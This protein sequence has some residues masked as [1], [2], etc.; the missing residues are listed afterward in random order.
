MHKLRLALTLVLTIF[1]VAI[2]H[3]M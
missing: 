3:L 2:S 1:A